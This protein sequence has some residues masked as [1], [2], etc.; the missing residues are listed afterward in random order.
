MKHKKKV[1][2]RKQLILQ[3]LDPIACLKYIFITI[4]QNVWPNP[5]SGAKRA[6]EVVFSVLR[7]ACIDHDL[8]ISDAIEASNDIFAQN[9]IQLYKINIGRELFDS[10]ASESPSYMIGTNV[11]EHSVSLVRIVWVDTSGQHRCR[12]RFPFLTI[13]INRLFFEFPSSV[14]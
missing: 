13:N 14:S 3:V 10:K 9:A 7:D 6:R 5:L 11:P 8:S 12:V 1:F 4:V 2:I